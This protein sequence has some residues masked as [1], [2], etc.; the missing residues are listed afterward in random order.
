MHLAAFIGLTAV[1]VAIPGPS[2]ML[3]MKATMLRGRSS[4][5]LVACGVLCGD[6]IWAAAAVAGIT[7]LIVASGPAFE[8]LRLAGAAYLIYLG[9][10]LLLARGE[11]HEHAPSPALRSR[12]SFVEGLLC[13]LSNPKSLIVFTSVIPQFLSPHP[14]AA[15][16]ALFGVLFAVLGFASLSVYVGALAATRR[17]VRGRLTDR[18]L[19]ASGALLVAFGIDLVADR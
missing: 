19:R 1:I 5:M 12:R 7:A 15:E 11:K 9:L 16:V 10:K 18:L 3:V 14:P 17:V 8:V 2:V 6:F 13:E 4:A